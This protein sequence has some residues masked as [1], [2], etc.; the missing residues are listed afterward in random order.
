MHCT[1]VHSRTGYRDMQGL[2]SSKNSLKSSGFNWVYTVEYCYAVEDF[3]EFN[4]CSI[5]VNNFN[6]IVFLLLFCG[7]NHIVIVALVLRAII[8]EARQLLHKLVQSESHRR[9]LIYQKRYLEMLIH[10]ISQGDSALTSSS[11][12]VSGL[13]RFRVAVVAICFILRWDMSVIVTL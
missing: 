10:F 13:R 5:F 12:P 4:D 3:L 6:F 8:V 7:R 2:C 1:L 11:R 9:A